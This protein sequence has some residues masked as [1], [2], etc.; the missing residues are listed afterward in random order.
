MR[1]L[2]YMAIVLLLMNYILHQQGCT[3]DNL[4]TEY[5]DVKVEF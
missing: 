5:P 3:S 1:F 4:H 2:C